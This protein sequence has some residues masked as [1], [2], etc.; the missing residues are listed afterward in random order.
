MRIRNA[1]KR[2]NPVEYY[3]ENKNT[4]TGREKTLGVDMILKMAQNVE[5]RETFGL[6]N[7]IITI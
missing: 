5:Y 7:L 6:N 2:F 3:Y 4:E 1:G